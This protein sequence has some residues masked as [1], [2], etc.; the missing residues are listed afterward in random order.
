VCLAELVTA[1]H[2]EKV[3]DGAAGVMS[4]NK[5]FLEWCLSHID[6]QHAHASARMLSSQGR[7]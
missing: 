5:K 7:D 6:R 3:W 2:V 1:G 4:K